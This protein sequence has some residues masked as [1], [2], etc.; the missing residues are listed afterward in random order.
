MRPSAPAG[1]RACLHTCQRCC[2]CGVLLWYAA[3]VCCYCVLPPQQRPPCAPWRKM[4]SPVGL[5]PAIAAADC[6]QAQQQPQA[7]APAPSGRP[8]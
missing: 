3:A 2:C 7:S 4:P 6:L 5:L 8:L 1:A